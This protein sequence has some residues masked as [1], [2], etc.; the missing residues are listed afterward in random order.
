MDVQPWYFGPWALT[1]IKY[2]DAIN[3]TAIYKSKLV[4]TAFLIII[5]IPF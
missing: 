5:S 4:V 2:P 3:K 1:K